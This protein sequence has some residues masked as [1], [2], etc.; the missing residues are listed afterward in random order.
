MT[1]ILAGFQLLRLM[2]LFLLSQHVRSMWETLGNIKVMMDGGTT[3]ANTVLTFK[4]V[5]VGF[6]Q[7]RVW[8]VYSGNTTATNIIG[9]Y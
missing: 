6:H 5:P 3:S 8:R 2:Q 9:V 1:H 7:L 4:N